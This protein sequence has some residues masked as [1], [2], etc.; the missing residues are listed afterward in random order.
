MFTVSCGAYPTEPPKYA[1]KTH[2]MDSIKP[3][4]LKSVYFETLGAMRNLLLL[5]F[6]F[7]LILDLVK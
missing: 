7:F 1:R 3:L 4:K 6:R 2:R 5:S